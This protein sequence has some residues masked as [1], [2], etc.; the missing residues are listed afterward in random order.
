[1]VKVENDKDD[2]GYDVFEYYVNRNPYAKELI[3]GSK[4]KFHNYTM[5]TF[6]NIT[7]RN[8]SATAAQKGWFDSEDDKFNKLSYQLYVRSK[9]NKFLIFPSLYQ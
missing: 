2:Y 9:F 3:I 8:L 5:Q 4:D 1:M 7:T 6:I